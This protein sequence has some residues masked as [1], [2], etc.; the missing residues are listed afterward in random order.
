VGGKQEKPAHGGK[1]L[2]SWRKKRQDQ[3]FS[4]DGLAEGRLQ[5]NHPR[6]RKMKTT[7]EGNY[8]LQEFSNASR[9]GKRVRGHKGRQLWKEGVLSYPDP[10]RIH[11]EGPSVGCSQL[12]YQGGNKWGVE[13]KFL[14][15]QGSRPSLRIT[16]RARGWK[17]ANSKARRGDLD[18]F[19]VGLPSKGRERGPI[20]LVEFNPQSFRRDGEPT[21]RCM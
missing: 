9:P 10:Y 16:L 4:G 5:Q 14:K 21:T 8:W 18:R 1:I 6:K 17:G 19:R 20:S 2:I 11:K 7:V 13:T 3:G 15:L 12:L